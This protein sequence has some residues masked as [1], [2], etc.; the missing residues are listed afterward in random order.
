MTD[1]AIS[2]SKANNVRKQK[3]YSVTSTPSRYGRKDQTMASHWRTVVLSG[4][5]MLPGKAVP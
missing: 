5:V 4:T 1:A 3:T 2:R